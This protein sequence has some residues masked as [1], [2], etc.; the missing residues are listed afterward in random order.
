[1]KRLLVVALLAAGLVGCSRCGGG[2]KAQATQVERLLPKGAVAVVV[3]PKLSE[4][5]RALSQV[6][7]FKAAGFFAQLQGFPN[8]RA[9]ADALVSE[10]G[11][12]PRSPEA[13]A[14]AGLD[15]E[16]SVGAA[17]LVS[18]QVVLIVPVKDE[19]KLHLTVEG[20]AYKRLGAGAGAEQKTGEVV[21]KTFAPQQGQPPAVGYT[22]KDGFALLAKGDAVGRLA[23]LATLTESDSLASDA[24]LKAALAAAPAER[25]VWAWAPEGSPALAQAPMKSAL[26]T[27]R[28]DAK[29]LAV[30]VDGAWKLEPST[31]AALVKKDAP[32]LEGFLPKDAFV[33]ARTTGDPAALAPMLEGV[34]GPSLMRAFTEAGFDPKVEILGNLAPGT[35]FALSLAE[36]PPLAGGVPELDVRRTNPFS[37]VHLSGAALPVKAEA[38]VPTLEKV[39]AVAP[40][41]GASMNKVERKGATAWFTSYSQGEGVHFAVKD[42][43]VFFG[44]PMQRLDALL[45]SDG[46]GEAPVKGLTQDALSLALDL[47]KLAASVRALPE[48]AWG[49]GG[50]AMKAASVRWLEAI[51][52][53]VGVTVTASA[54]DGAVHARLVLAREAPAQG[55]PK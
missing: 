49:I 44:S 5:G 50:F 45:E 52:D 4:L 32:P 6:E 38:V 21:V 23:A 24:V 12:D 15:G 48:S 11:V 28:L 55:A 51:D 8:G 18:G 2:A 42:G 36:R 41:F 30:S 47:K 39:A 26:V 53:L 27:A 19:K 29:A 17:L 25:D 3:V 10:L 9:V 46:K 40:R 7:T 13:L 43:H 14:K 31:L 16:R 1:M 37:F 20:L 54:K 33:A 22:V 35:T 34:L